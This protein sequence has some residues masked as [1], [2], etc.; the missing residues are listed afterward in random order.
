MCLLSSCLAM[1]VSSDFAIPGF[2]LNVTIFAHKYVC[3]F[4]KYS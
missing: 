2:G 4:I 3:N 1:D